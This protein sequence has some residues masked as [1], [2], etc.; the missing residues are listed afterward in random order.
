MVI[1]GLFK[2]AE[3]LYGVDIRAQQVDV[4]AEDVTYYTISEQG[5]TITHFI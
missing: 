3:R 4:W 5:K 1:D 2:I